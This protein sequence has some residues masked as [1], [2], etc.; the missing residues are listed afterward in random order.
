MNCY[1]HHGVPA[2]GLCKNCHKGLCRECA[3]DVGNGLACKDS[4]ETAVNE[5]NDIFQRTK[6][7]YYRLG[8]NYVRGVWL[9]SIFGVTFCLVGL[10]LLYF[11]THN[12]PAALPTIVISFFAFYGA[13]TNYRES[14]KHKNSL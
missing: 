7:Q 8:S 1:Y 5:I 12:W 10:L 6:G 9:A 4:C 13:I 14:K 2:I 11:Y 3:V